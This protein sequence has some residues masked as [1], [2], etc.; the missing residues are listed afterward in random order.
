MHNSASVLENDTGDFD[1]Q[2]DRLIS[3]RRPD[4]IVINNNNKKRKGK[5]KKRK[6]RE[7]VKLWTL[8]Y[9]LATE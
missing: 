9:R 7:L 4:L 3:A 5:K 6:K 2:T 8:L 1:I